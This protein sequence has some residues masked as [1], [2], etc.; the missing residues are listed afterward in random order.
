MLAST[1]MMRKS[2]YLD[3]CAHFGAPATADRLSLSIPALRIRNGKTTHYRNGADEAIEQEFDGKYGYLYSYELSPKQDVHIP[4][5]VDL[6]DI[7]VL[8]LMQGNSDIEIRGI[9]EK[10]ISTL[11]PERARYF[12]LPPHSYTLLIPPGITRL[13]GFYFDGGLFRDG[14][15][16]GFRFLRELIQGYRGK[17][18]T[19]IASIDFTVDLRTRLHIEYLCRN[20]KKEDFNN[21]SFI[22]QQLSKLIELSQKKVSEPS[23]TTPVTSDYVRF[24][25][26]QIRKEIEAG[27]GIPFLEELASKTGVSLNYL[28]KLHRL[29]HHHT[30]REYSQSILIAVAVDLLK[31]GIPPTQVSYHLNYNSP[32]AFARFVKRKTG[33]TPAA[34]CRQ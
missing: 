27:N 33:K 12:Y 24:A 6:G 17:S 4:I 34:W 26:A 2:L 32:S 14:N 28:N 29:Q 19:P 31:K 25:R 1:V 18:A 16:R 3:L 22:L 10:L 15:E 8:Y 20:L 11:S 7:H 23:D 9:Q 21:E 5:N 30:L 13:F